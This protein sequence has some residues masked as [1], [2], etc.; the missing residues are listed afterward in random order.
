VPMGVT[1]R[2]R[3][4]FPRFSTSVHLPLV[5]PAGSLKALYEAGLLGRHLRC[6]ANRSLRKVRDRL[7]AEHRGSLTVEG[8]R[9][10][11]FPAPE[12]LLAVSSVA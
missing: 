10:F 9:F 8:T 3:S 2:P 12:R 4:L 5:A 7:A 1:R 11:T 6:C